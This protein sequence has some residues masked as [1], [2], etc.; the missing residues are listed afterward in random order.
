MSKLTRKDLPTKLFKP[1][2]GERLGKVP[3][4]V[5]GYYAP[6]WKFKDRNRPDPLLVEPERLP[7]VTPRDPIIPP[8][9]YGKDQD[10]FRGIAPG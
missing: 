5:R 10:P 8:G 7:K 4:P 9:Q 6:T 3:K 2:V 1:G